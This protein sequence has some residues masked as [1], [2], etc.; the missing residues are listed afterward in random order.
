[1][2]ALALALTLG[3]LGCASSPRPVAPAERFVRRGF[4]A[5]LFERRGIC[6]S[7]YRAGQGPDEHKFPSDAEVAEDLELLVRGGWR[8]VRLFDSG[9]HAERVLRVIQARK[10]DVKVYLGVWIAGGK[11]EHDAANRAEIDRAAALVAR[12]PDT[13]VAVSVGNETLDDWSAV[14]TPPA[15]LAD[16]IRQT[17]RRV[18][19]PV[20]TDDAWQPI[21]LATVGETSYADVLQVLE[22][23]DFASIHIYAFAEAFH[24]GWDWKQEAVPEAQRA[25]AMMAAAIARTKESAQAVRAALVAHGLGD[26]PIDVGERGWKS[27]TMH[28]PASP[29]ERAIEV[30]F[31][32]PVNQRIFYDA[33]SAWIY[34][35][36]R[37]PDAPLAS[38]YFEA[39][40]EPWKD[41]HGDDG[42]GLFDVTRHAKPAIEAAFPD[43]KPA[44]APTY[45]PG[46][47]V[48]YR[49]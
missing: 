4:P 1:M 44:D 20:T 12:Y 7:G 15:E 42:W 35:D 5:G 11:A 49:P 48:H 10:L 26:M 32:H 40:D 29:P 24:G 13:I 18:A 2:R 27:K 22:T 25:Q 43:R 36:A 17:R 21:A 47:A 8:L 3:L 28:T 16:Y 41:Q 38:F 33:V 6:Y 14:R 30:F 45:A 19:L 34:G 9:E 46:D 23:I 31:S 37:A 39:F